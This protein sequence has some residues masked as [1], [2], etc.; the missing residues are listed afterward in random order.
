[1]ANHPDR[2]NL[3][4][5]FTD[6]Q[7]ADT[8]AAYGNNDIRTPNLNLLSKQSFVFE[9]AYASQPVC[10]SSRST[11][12]TGTYPHTNGCTS[13]NIALHRDAKTIAEMV[14]GDYRRG[15]YGKW[16]LGNDLQ[17]Q[18]GFEEWLTIEDV[19]RSYY[20]DKG[21]LDRY[22]DY[23]QYLIEQGYEPDCAGDELDPT[24]EGAPQ[25]DT[26]D[27]RMVFSRMFAANLPAEQ[28][29]A[30]FLGRRVEQFIHESASDPRPFMLYANSLEPHPP[31]T[32]PND[33]LHRTNRNNE[34]D[35]FLS[36][37]PENTSMINRVHANHLAHTKE[38]GEDLSKDAGW[39]RL[40]SRYFGL[41]ASVD[42]ALGG[43]LKALEDSGQAQ[44]TIIV[45]T[46]EHGEMM[47][48]HRMLYKSSMYQEAIRVPLL[49]RVP[50]LEEGS[51]TISGS[52]SHIDL[53]P[54]L[55]ELLGERIPGHLQGESRLPVILGDTDLSGNDVV[56]QWNGE[57]GRHQHCP[58]DFQN[59][60]SQKLYDEIKGLPWRTIMTS[61]G[62]KLSINRI[63]QC[64]LY[65][66]N[67]DPYETSNLYAHVAER[68]RVRDLV[69]RIRLWQERH[70]D[71]IQVLP[72]DWGV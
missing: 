70:K 25:T 38:Q 45:F 4:F 72:E 30:A 52:I 15:Y 13:N 6:E 60:F 43:I 50:W 26:G 21:D 18:H 28:T 51:R 20:S 46:S 57:D 1:M 69:S 34:G 14:S 66:L 41:V 40:R 35:S 42:E 37:P 68:D 58:I 65:N 16:H 54:T 24:E 33:K 64:E 11:I 32:G 62:W 59:D 3:L 61:D 48:D 36:P 27:S 44:N 56:V 67:N 5:I 49:V 8:M 71:Y 53:V 31:F 19:Y 23:H 10:T 12:L 29:K 9:N 55:L 22:S 39:R 7:R 17:P 63:D 47:G 2:P